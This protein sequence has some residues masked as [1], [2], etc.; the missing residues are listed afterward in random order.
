MVPE[1]THSLDMPD[2]LTLP[3]VYV[4]E[5]LSRWEL[6]DSY[7]GAHWDGYYRAPVGRNRGSD[8]ITQSNWDQQWDALK[9]FRADV[10]GADEVSPVA[11]CENHWL[12]GWVEWVA[13]HESNGPALREADRLA[14]ALADYPVL[15]DEDFSRRE[16]E[17]YENGWKDYGFK[18]FIQEIRDALELRHSTFDAM[19][20]WDQEET[21][22]FFESLIPSGEY[23]TPYSDG[24]SIRT[25]SAIRHLNRDT[26]AKFLRAQRNKPADA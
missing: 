15:D 20:D 8:L 6:P 9:A 5:H 25:D 19:E 14:G 1:S 22:E 12:V 11:V 16:W 26:L 17:D 4:P 21:Q 18:D 3:D 23:F 13:I 7:A 2:T 24:V 10:P